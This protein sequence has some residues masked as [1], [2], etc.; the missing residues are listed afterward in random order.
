MKWKEDQRINRETITAVEM[1]GIPEA[2]AQAYYERLIDHIAF[3]QEAGA[4]AGITA[5]KL[6]RHDASKFTVFEFPGYAYHFN[7]KLD[8]LIFA[9]AWLNH[10]HNNDHHWQY[11]LFADG[12]APE[13]SPIINGALPMPDYAIDEM[14]ADWQGASRAHNGTWD[15]S[16]WLAKA[17]SR[18]R[19]H[20][21]TAVIVRDRLTD[22]LKVDR[23]IANLI[24]I[25]GE[26]K[27]V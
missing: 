3:V 5:P 22:Q 10:I 4:L 11:W 27:G 21:E 24:P 7:V 18:I 20:P 8:Y 2:A 17:G 23:E 13:G 25:A 14:I 9:P 16:L 19:L 6:D 26:G 1:L 12:W 15:V